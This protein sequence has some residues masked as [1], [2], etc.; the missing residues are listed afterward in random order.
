MDK[1]NSRPRYLNLFKIAM[2]VTAVV[3]IAHR[4]SGFLLVIT[5]PFLIYAFQASVSSTNEFSQLLATLQ[6]PWV[7]AILI[8]LTWSFAHHFFAGIRFLLIDVDLGV[9]KKSARHSAW[10]IHFLAIVVTAVVV[11]ALL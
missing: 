9:S 2:P 4:L 11:G 7:K 6:Q 10:L 3:S 5:I 8:V 1:N